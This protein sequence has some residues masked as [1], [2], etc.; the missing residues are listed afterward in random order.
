MQR[1]RNPCENA[2]VP[3]HPA[4]MRAL[5]ALL[6]ALLLAPGAQAARAPAAQKTPVV[7]L[8][9]A[10]FPGVPEG[11]AAR[12][13]GLLAQELRGREELRLV[14]LAAQAP[15]DPADP[16]AQARLQLAKAAA[17]AQKS[18]HAAAAEALEK[19]MGLLTSRPAALDAAAGALL[20]GAALQLAVER[21]VSGDEDGGEAALAQ[22]VRLAPDRQLNPADYPPAFLVE[23]QGVRKR[24]LSAP[25]GSLRV[26]APSGVGEA[27]VLVDG[28]EAPAAPVLVT[29]LV[30]GEHFV[31]VERGGARW[32][33][34]FVAIA[35][36]ETRVAPQPGVEGPA[37]DLT[38]ALLLGE[39]DRAAV[40][41]AGRLARSA[42]AQ[43]AVFGALI[44]RGEKLLLR[45]FLCLARGDR[46]AAL[47]TL[48]LDVELLGGVVQAVKLGDDVVAKLRAFPAEPPLPLALGAPAPAAAQEGA[49]A[50]PPAAQ[51]EVALAPLIAPA[52]EPDRAVAAPEPARVVAVPGAPVAAAA[53]APAPVAAPAREP[54]AAELPSRAL[55]IP[56]QP[57]PD[58]TEPPRARPAEVL[59]PAPTHLVALEPEAIKTAREA[60][61]RSSHTALWIVAGVLVA[62]AAA[63]GGYFLYQSGQTPTTAN[64]NATWGH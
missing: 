56:R 14:E 34:K 19:A 23:L 9:Y 11:L 1:L 47:P 27:R 10:I 45:S 18:R 12:I 43:A 40:M 64:V 33:Q 26:L 17:L 30:P 20:T 46:V 29:D 54:V 53:P 50:P 61:P 3:R 52:P 28:R 21:L 25:R 15:A 60:P 58:E 48:E 36:V 37:A 31:R 62:G 63:A 41:A 24:L 42:G 8:P 16:V 51:P 6:S 4:M 5:A 38:S 22:L 32:G 7:V 49:A 59:R 55:V 13:D 44:K 39:L 35:G 2:A 57:T